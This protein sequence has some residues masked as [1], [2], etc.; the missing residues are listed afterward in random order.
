MS[1]LLTGIKIGRLTGTKLSFPS[2][3][4]QKNVPQ[5]IYRPM[6]KIAMETREDKTALKAKPFFTFETEKETEFRSR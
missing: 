4:G 3:L 5:I 6:S 1:L 2:P